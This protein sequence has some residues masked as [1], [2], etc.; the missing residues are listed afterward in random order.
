ML[1]FCPAE[2]AGQV[3]SMPNVH[4][5]EHTGWPIMSKLPVHTPLSHSVDV[6]LTVTHAAPNVR[7]AGPLASG[8]GPGALPE[9]A[10]RTNDHARKRRCMPKG[11]NAARGGR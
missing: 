7:G 8:P 5:T 11:Y 4:F 3:E 2:P 9:H 10:T 1:H 6:S